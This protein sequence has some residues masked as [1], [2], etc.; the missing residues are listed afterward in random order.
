MIMDDPIFAG[1]L[2]AQYDEIAE[3][4]AASDILDVQPQGG[5]ACQRYLLVFHCPG[6]VKTEAGG[7]EVAD[8]FVVGVRFPHDYLARVSVPEVLAF[9]APTSAFHANIRFPYV[10]IGKIHPGC[11]ITELAYR[12]YEVITMQNRN[13]SEHD[14]LNAEACEWI[15]NNNDRLPLSTAPLR[16]RERH[17]A[18][19]IVVEEL[20]A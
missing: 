20:P 10:C 12:V 7:V 19:A 18:P 16:R 1:F 11:P 4:A 6:L 5:P 17:D 13:T 15:R 3:L 2:K 14:A 9:L 8:E